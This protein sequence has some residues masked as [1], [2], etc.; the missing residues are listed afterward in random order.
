[1]AKPRNPQPPRPRP[2]PADQHPQEDH[3]VESWPGP[4]PLLEGSGRPDPHPGEGL[5]NDPPGPD[6]GVPGPPPGGGPE[7]IAEILEALPDSADERYHLTRIRPKEYKGEKTAGYLMEIQAGIT[8]QELKD[9]IGGGDYE[10]RISGPRGRYIGGRSFSLPGPPKIDGRTAGTSTEPAAGAGKILGGL[11]I[12]AVIGLGKE[13]IGELGKAAKNFL[14]NEDRTLKRLEAYS[15]IVGGGGGVKSS[16]GELKDLLQLTKDLHREVGGGGGD[17]ESW[18]AVIREIATP[19]I[20]EYRKQTAIL[21]E[22]MA[23]GRPGRPAGPPTVLNPAGRA[24]A[25]PEEPGP[26]PGGFDAQARFL[27]EGLERS[28]VEGF[29]PETWEDILQVF[30]TDQ[31]LA[32]IETQPLEVLESLIDPYVEKSQILKSEAGRKYIRATLEVL[33]SMARQL[34]DQP[35]APE[36]PADPPAGSGPESLPDPVPADPGPEKPPPVAA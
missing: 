10:I 28:I 35:P 25:P 3:Q 17:P 27:V 8:M 29:P 15:K 33:Q 2:A 19:V 1:M 13:L 30:A 5:D 7:G 31:V 9:Q 26:V 34:H 18:P 32:F 12:N 24:D 22:R 23:Q 4:E 14:D 6:L 36:P 20:T 21:R 11:D 16:I